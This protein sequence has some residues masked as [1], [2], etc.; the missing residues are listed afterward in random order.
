MPESKSTSTAIS[1]QK[2]VPDELDLTL[3]ATLIVSRMLRVRILRAVKVQMHVA[4]RGLRKLYGIYGMIL[5]SGPAGCGK[6]TI[7][8]VVA[9]AVM[10]S[11]P[12]LGRA[13]VLGINCHGIFSSEFGGSQKNVEALFARLREVAASG[14]RLFIVIDEVETLMA[15]RQSLNNGANPK[16][17]HSSVNAVIEKIDELVRQYSNVFIIATTN[18]PESIDPALRDRF[19]VHIAIGLPGPSERLTIVSQTMKGFQPGNCLASKLRRVAECL[20]S[21]LST[22]GA[23]TADCAELA[24]CR[25]LIAAT[26]GL[27]G[28]KLS[29]LP[30]HAL[31]VR[32]AEP[33]SHVTLADLVNAAQQMKGMK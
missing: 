8:R 30:I 15:D 33:G 25:S 3:W 12:R 2:V 16:D 6:S 27:S 7:A 18:H 5:L 24:E 29:R 23:T 26:E 11:H 28:R 31:I 10:K 19:D 22:D 1:V 14:V 4:S 13:V 9:S 17:Y 20:E 21:R 32:D